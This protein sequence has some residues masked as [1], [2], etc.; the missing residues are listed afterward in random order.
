[1][2]RQTNGNNFTIRQTDLFHIHTYRCRH[3]DDVPDESYVLK[4]IE[5]GA[6]GIWF[7][8]HAPFPGNRLRNRMLYEELDGYIDS[9][10]GL[11]RAYTGRIDVHLGLEIEY[12]PE[13]DRT[14]Y[15]D[16]LRKD[17]RFEILIQG[18]HMAE[19]DQE[20]GAYT[21][22]WDRERLKKEEYKALMNA[23]I[24]GIDTGRFDAVAHPDRSFRRCREWTKDM[25]ALS[26][27]LIDKANEKGMPIEINMH[28][29]GNKHQF[30]PEFW[31]IARNK[32]SKI[33]IGLDAHSP[34]EMEKRKKRGDALFINK[35]GDD[36]E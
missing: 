11:K 23:L 28:S 12:L 31:E 27:M 5:M 24:A 3:A 14:G 18:Q 9:I 22:D 2:S 17:D 34:D 7:T 32:D 21:F 15:Y 10:I 8:D 1:M 29:F 36:I 20:Q 6:T 35:K 30:W 16:E 26:E 4:A 33:I 19:D 13:Y 25:A